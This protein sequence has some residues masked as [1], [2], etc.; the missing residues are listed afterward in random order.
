MLKENQ[1]KTT[2]PIDDIIY[3]KLIISDSGKTITPIRNGVF[4]G[5][6]KSLWGFNSMEITSTYDNGRKIKEI[7]YSNRKIVNCSN[8]IK[9]KT[10]Y[11]DSN[12]M[13]C[14]DMEVNYNWKINKGTLYL[15]KLP[16]TLERKIC[17]VNYVQPSSID[18]LLEFTKLLGNH[19]FSRC[20]ES[21]L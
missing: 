1:K 13:Y 7:V 21:I 9:N 14:H 10:I 2:C 16:K 15:S 12:S 19:E 3:G 17:E 5:V 11:F 4:H 20:I 6:S 8:I 18:E